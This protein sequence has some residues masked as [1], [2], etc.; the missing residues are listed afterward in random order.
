[1]IKKLQALKAKKGFTLV[2]LVVVIAIIGVLAAIL[3]PVMIGVVQDANITSADSLAKQIYSNTQTFCTKADTAKHSLK[4]TKA[5]VS[6]VYGV[7]EVKIT[8]SD[9]TGAVVWTVDT[10]NVSDTSTGTTLRFGDASKY[11]FSGTAGTDSADMCLNLYLADTLRDFTSG[12]VY[13]YFSNGACVGAAVQQGDSNG[14]ELVSIATDIGDQYETGQ[15]KEI[16]WPGAK[17]GVASNSAIIG[18]S[19]KIG[20]STSAPAAGGTT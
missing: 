6:G 7:T 10:T 17:A 16:N 12:V 5:A 4:N 19:P 9:T 15:S 1:M 18:T 2:E 8:V 20:H 14:T 3:I 11:K 13:V